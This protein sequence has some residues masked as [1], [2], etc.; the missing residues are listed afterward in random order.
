M[1]KARNQPAHPGMPGQFR[2]RSTIRAMAD[3]S[4]LKW[5]VRYVIV[6]IIGGGGVIAIVVAV[7]E[8]THVP[9]HLAEPT[10]Q[11]QTD[12]KSN[13]T[14]AQPKAEQGAAIKPA[15]GSAPLLPILPKET[16]SSAS[17]PQQRTF[18]L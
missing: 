4:G 16:D 1:T 13:S 17:N 6:P 3:E 7:I 12:H 8:R 10:I 18:I 14:E 9:N 15:Q 2:G 5:W 11:V